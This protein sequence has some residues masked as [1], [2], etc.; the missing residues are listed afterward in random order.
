M[1]V[2]SIVNWLIDIFVF[3]AVSAIF[4]AYACNGGVCYR[5]LFETLKLDY[6]EKKYL[7]MTSI[8]TLSK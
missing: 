1:E 6:K 5:N 8:E 3:Y 7:R 4:Q 2:S